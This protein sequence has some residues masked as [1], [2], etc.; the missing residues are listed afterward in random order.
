MQTLGIVPVVLMGGV[1]SGAETTW[2]PA[3]LTVLT[4]LFLHGGWLHLIGNMLFL[5]VFGDNVEDSMGHLRFVAF[6]L[7]CGIA[8]S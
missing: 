8:A 5:W 2:I 4:S 7:L 3:E 6:Y 1:P